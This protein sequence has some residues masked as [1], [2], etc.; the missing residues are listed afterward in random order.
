MGTSKQ[1]DE[2]G[3]FEELNIDVPSVLINEWRASKTSVS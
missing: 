3:M 1:T 2:E